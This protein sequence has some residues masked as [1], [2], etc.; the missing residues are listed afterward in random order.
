MFILCSWKNMS[1]ETHHQN[2]I[3]IV[4]T[5]FLYL[6]RTSTISYLHPQH[7]HRTPLA[8]RSRIPPVELLFPAWGLLHHHPLQRWSARP[9]RCEWRG[10]FAHLPN[11]HLILKSDHL[12]LWLKRSSYDVASSNIRIYIYIHVLY[13][14][15]Y[16]V[17]WSWSGSTR[18]VL[19]T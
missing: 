6:F 5:I 3:E 11:D 10:C 9:R 19:M 12:F 17:A 1:K 18:E 14:Y 4:E 8:L 15:I 7:E 2:R 13:M 16:S